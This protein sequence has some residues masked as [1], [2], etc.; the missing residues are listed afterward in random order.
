MSLDAHDVEH[1]VK[2]GALQRDRRSGGRRPAV[3][4]SLCIVARSEPL[5]LRACIENAL[6]AADELVVVLM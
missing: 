5:Y 3:R 6:P 1:V 4:L 2:G